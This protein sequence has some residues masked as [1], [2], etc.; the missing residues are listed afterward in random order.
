MGINTS[1]Y[2][3]KSYGYIFIRIQSKERKRA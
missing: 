3:R 1:R 2:F